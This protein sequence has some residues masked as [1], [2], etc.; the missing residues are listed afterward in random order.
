M[1]DKKFD[2]EQSEGEDNEEEDDEAY[3]IHGRG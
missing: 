1:E 3:E 2:L